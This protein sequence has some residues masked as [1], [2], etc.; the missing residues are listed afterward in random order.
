MLPEHEVTTRALNNKA[1]IVHYAK[2]VYIIPS[3][4]DVFLSLFIRYS[5]VYIHFD[6]YIHVFLNVVYFSHNGFITNMIISVL[7]FD[8]LPALTFICF[9][10]E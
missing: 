3:L 9:N 7:V 1:D 10:F 6:E 5:C 2:Y 4:G 8:F